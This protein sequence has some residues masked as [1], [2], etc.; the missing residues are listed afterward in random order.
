MYPR[1]NMEDAVPIKE[2][3][4]IWHT[5]T[6][7][8]KMRETSGETCRQLPQIWVHDGTT[9][10]INSEGFHDGWNG[11]ELGHVLSDGVRSAFCSVRRCHARSAIDGTAGGA[12]AYALCQTNIHME[13]QDYC[14]RLWR[15]V[16]EWLFIGNI[17]GEIV[18]EH[19]NNRAKDK[20]WCLMMVY[21]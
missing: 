14:Q 15:H 3:K 19:A 21:P 10:S 13:M 5:N 6:V 12:R 2:Y 4:K 20:D 11:V 8:L 17:P 7:N 9:E 16:D 1:L 18:N